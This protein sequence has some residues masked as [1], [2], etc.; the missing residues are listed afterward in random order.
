MKRIGTILISLSVATLVALFFLMTPQP[1][2]AEQPAEHVEI[3]TETENDS[4]YVISA[5]S[6]VRIVITIQKQE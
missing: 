3:I 4:D 1:A 2:V 6:G 5:G